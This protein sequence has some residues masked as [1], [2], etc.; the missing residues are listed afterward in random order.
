MT[1][2]DIAEFEKRLR[3]AELQELEDYKCGTGD[4]PIIYRAEGVVKTTEAGKPT[5]FIASEETEDRF[6]DIILLDGWELSN[7]KRN[8]VFLFTHNHSL[9]PIGTVPKVWPDGK[10]LLANVKWDD[11]DEFAAFIH[12]KY[13]REVMRAVSVGFRAL[14][15]ENREKGVEFKRQELL[16]LSAVPIPAHPA[17]L[18]KVMNTQKFHIVVPEIT[19]VEP[20]EPILEEECPECEETVDKTGIEELRVELSKVSELIEQLLASREPDEQEPNVEENEHE[21]IDPKDI[22]AVREFIADLKKH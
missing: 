6:G 10:Q 7:F 13:D 19:S 3:E 1:G 9:A 20:I 12:G 5:V 11:Q 2:F 14:E 18:Q 15:F 8:P 17:A 4:A 21:Q 22:S 16:E